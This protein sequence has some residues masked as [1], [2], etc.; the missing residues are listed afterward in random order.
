[1]HHSLMG[2]AIWMPKLIASV[3][4]FTLREIARA[5]P[6]DRATDYNS[7]DDKTPQTQ[8]YVPLLFH[9]AKSRLVR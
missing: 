6:G 8:K 1:M 7:Q 9:N 3:D 4:S 5:P 2:G